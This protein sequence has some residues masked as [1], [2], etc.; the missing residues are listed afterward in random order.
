MIGHFYNKSIRKYV[1]LMQQLFSNIVVDRGPRGFHQVP[2]TYASKE[3]YRAALESMVNDPNLAKIEGVL[4]RISLHL[5]NLVYDAT[6]ATNVSNRQLQRSFNEDRPALNSQFNPV[7][8]DF[9]FEMGIFTRH[10]DDVFQIVEQICPYFRPH[11]TCMIKELDENEL[12]IDKRDIP[13]VLE[14]IQPQEEFEGPGPI[15]RRIEW[16][17]SFKVKGWLYPAT[18]S[19]FGEIRTIYLNFNND[20]RELMVIQAE[21]E[22]VSNS[23]SVAWTNRSAQNRDLTLS[24]SGIISANV[25]VSW[26]SRDSVFGALNVQYNTQQSQDSSTELSWQVE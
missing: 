6:R 14:T 8:Y 12:V 16:T 15:L 24:W 10:Q 19:Q 2:I 9:Y 26:N 5:V 3:K 13:I 18:N 11:F 4:P 1:I 17:L 23:C 21:R 20:E 25:G 7:P 22:P